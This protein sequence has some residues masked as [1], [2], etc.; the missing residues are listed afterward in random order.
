MD[1]FQSFE[2]DL[3]AFLAELGQNNNRDWFK[4]HQARYQETVLEP[5]FAFIRAM[6]PRIWQISPHFLAEAKK[7]GGSMFRIQRDTRFSKDKTPYKTH[8]GLRFPHEQAK[9]TTAPGFYLRLSPE[10]TILGVGMWHPDTASLARIRGRID[11]EPEQWLGAKEDPN[12]RRH[13]ELAGESLK[14]PPRGYPKDHPLLED[15]KRKDFVGFREMEFGNL[16]KESFIDEVTAAF[17]SSHAF[18]EF[19]CGALRLPF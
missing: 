6:A 8:L 5:A 3:I 16:F 15:L 9:K 13:F 12:F 10:G 18:M 4:A 17:H 11:S 2:P 14:K 7:V 1:N 19:L